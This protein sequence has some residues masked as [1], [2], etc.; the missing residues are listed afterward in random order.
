MIDLTKKYTTR[1]GR[2]VEIFSTNC[3]DCLGQS[4]VTG[5]YR[6]YKGQV[7]ATEWFPSGSF[8]R[9]GEFCELDLIEDIPVPVQ[10]ERLSLT[11]D[12]IAN[13]F[14]TASSTDHALGA[15]G[16]T[17]QPLAP[18][19]IVVDFWV[20]LY[21]GERQGHVHPTKAAAACA[22]DDSRIA[23]INIKRTI[24]EGDGIK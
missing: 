8:F 3:V 21:G 11:A 16:F 17:M 13:A 14:T 4:I 15:L 12:E 22:A 24:K 10:P 6:N 5:C 9:N 1:K 18:R 7:T 19:E 2:A 20:N 23:C